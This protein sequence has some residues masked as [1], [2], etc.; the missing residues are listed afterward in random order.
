VTLTAPAGKLTAVVGASGSGKSTLAALL[1]RSWDPTSGR[2]L[3]DGAPLDSTSLAELRSRVAVAT[4]R[5]YLF[6]LSIRE[7]LLLAKPDAT[8]RDLER[9][10][11]QARL[12]PVIESKEAGWDAPVGEL[13]ELLSG[14][15]RQRLALARALL[16]DAEVLVV[17]EATSQLDAATEAAVLAGLRRA[18]PDATVLMIAHRLSTVK[19]ADLIYVMD[20]GRVVQ[21]GVHSDLA[22]RPGAFA[23]LLAREEPAEASEVA[24]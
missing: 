6:N 3:L 16:R 15:E 21:R 23:D 4:Q 17:D 13:G 5:P 1:T 19:D 14:G 24:P 22:S 11:G 9:V 7:N 8:D 10:A 12:T 20:A 18:A 2:V